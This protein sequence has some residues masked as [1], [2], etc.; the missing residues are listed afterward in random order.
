MTWRPPRR[1]GRRYRPSPSTSRWCQPPSP[2][3]PAGRTARTGT[4]SWS[5]S[6]E[7]TSELQSPCNLV[8]RLLLE[9]NK[10]NMLYP[11]RSHLYTEN[12]SHV[13]RSSARIHNSDRVF[14]RLF[15]LRTREAPHPKRDL[16]YLRLLLS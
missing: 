1:T 3:G 12:D 7:H 16:F 6:E 5:R 9:K 11:S 10:E 14:C 2:P 13:I 15:C 4:G 8:C